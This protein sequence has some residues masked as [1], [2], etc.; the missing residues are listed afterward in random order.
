MDNEHALK[1]LNEGG[2]FIFL[3]APEGMEFG[4][5]MKLW[6]TGDKFRGVKMIPPGPHYIFFRYLRTYLF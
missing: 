5:D 3:D 1:L 6:T 4:I 2:F